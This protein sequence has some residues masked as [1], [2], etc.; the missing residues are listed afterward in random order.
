MIL[1]GD[2]P[3]Y[4]PYL[5]FFHKMI[6][7]DK[8]MIVDHVQY[9]KKSFQNRNRIRGPSGE[10]MLTVPV[11]SKGKFDQP[12]C[13]V[14]INN[15]INWQKKHHRTISLIYKK[16]PFF[17]DFK[18]F[19]EKI[20]SQR[21]EK[22]IELNEYIIRYVSKK[23]EIN[24]E[25]LKSSKFNFTGKKTDL[26][27]EM[28]KKTKVDTYLSGEGGR[29]YVDEKKFEENKLTNLFT[30][31]RHPVYKQLFEPFMP[32]MSIIDL[33]LNYDI[34]NSRKIIQECGKIGK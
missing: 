34:K 2:Q 12:I 17:D 1:V 11:L 27:I 26:L 24:L 8:Y 14:M 32:E 29:N 13:D 33:L 20:F 5:G 16:S 23:L 10:I 18:D 6:N 9:S 19:F 30:N 22:L 7:C 15:E 4:L 31:F 25:I 28:C 21:W 3:D